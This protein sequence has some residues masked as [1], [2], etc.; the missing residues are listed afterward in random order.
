MKRAGHSPT[1]NA[2]GRAD[3]IGQSI[4][5][6]RDARLL[7]KRQ[8]AQEELA[9][10]AKIDISCKAIEGYDIKSYTIQDIVDLYDANQINLNPEYQRAEVWRSPQRSK[11]IDTILNGYPSPTIILNERKD[12]DKIVYDAIDGKQRLESILYYMGKLRGGKHNRF[13]AKVSIT[14]DEDTRIEKVAWK[15]LTPESQESFMGYKL[16]CVIVYGAFSAIQDVFIRLNSTGSKLAQQEIRNAR[17]IRSPFLKAMRKFAHQM[18]KKLMDMNVISEGEITRM[19]DIEFLSELVIS[20]INVNVLDKKNLLDAM[21]GGAVDMRRA[22]KAIKTVAKAIKFVEKVLPEI[23]QTRFHKKSDFY[24]LVCWFAFNLDKLAFADKD[25]QSEAGALLREFAL[26]ADTDYENRRNGKKPEHGTT[27]LDY[28]QSVRDSSDSEKHR[29]DRAKILSEL[30]DGV[31]EE[32]DSRRIFNEL[33]RR[34][35]WAKAE[36]KICC[37]CGKPLDWDTFEVDHSKPYSK[38]GKT[39]LENAALIHSHCNKIKSNKT[40]GRRT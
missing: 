22:K 36:E 37:Y 12:N 40:K 14:E 28:I 18:R 10:M 8:S 35:I 1:V 25:R 32:K 34:I 7:S 17:F 20:V 16:P 26:M 31:F 4:N 33:Q 3:R 24:S 15:N 30:L 11:F 2:A 38:G 27:T 21:M 19:K 39:V 23:Q 5:N 6:N 29:L 9:K 13:V